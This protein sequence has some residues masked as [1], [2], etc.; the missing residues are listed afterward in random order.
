MDELD[1]R[2]ICKLLEDIKWTVE[3]CPN[4]VADVLQVELGGG[5]DNT[6]PGAHPGDGGAGE[7]LRQL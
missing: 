4:L 6:V 7:D 1:N 3:M 5:G 2:R